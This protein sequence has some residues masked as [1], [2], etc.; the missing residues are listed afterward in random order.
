[1]KEY[2]TCAE[3]PHCKPQGIRKD[4]FFGAGY[5]YGIC[6]QSGNV[7]ILEPWKEKRIHGSGYI[8]HK[9]SSCEMYEKEVNE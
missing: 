8:H 1:M 5:Q 4:G 9:V 2:L 3:C 6:G 7:V